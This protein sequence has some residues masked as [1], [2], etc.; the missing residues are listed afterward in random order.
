METKHDCTILWYKKS[1]L[2]VEMTKFSSKCTQI[3]IIG[4]FWG[5]VNYENPGEEANFQE[6]VTHENVAVTAR[7]R[8][9]ETRNGHRN[10]NRNPRWSSKVSF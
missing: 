6:S 7:S 2:W 9:D 8:E 1:M 10:A 4:L 5:S 3:Q